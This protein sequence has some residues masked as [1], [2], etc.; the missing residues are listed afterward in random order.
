MIGCSQAG[1]GGG[2]GGGGGQNPPGGGGSGSPAPKVPAGG[3]YTQ[4]QMKALSA[5]FSSA[6]AHVADLP[7]ASLFALSSDNAVSVADNALFNTTYRLLQLPQSPGAGA[8]TVDSTD[9]QINTAGVFNY[10]T[11]SNGTVTVNLPNRKG[12]HTS[13]TFANAETLQGF[14]LLHELGHEVGLF[15]PDTTASINGNN[16]NAVLSNCFTQT[17]GVYH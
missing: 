9:V 15:G 11:N 13:L 4:A 2:G 1:T 10:A 3:N 17:N 16:S 12:K 14:I 8:Q 7:C 5:G 6:L